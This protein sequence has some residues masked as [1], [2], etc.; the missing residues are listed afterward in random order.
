MHSLLIHLK[1]SI[2]DDQPGADPHGTPENH[3]R[4]APP[5]RGAL[6]LLVAMA[7]VLM[8]CRGIHDQLFDVFPLR[9]QM[10]DEGLLQGGDLEEGLLRISGY[11]EKFEFVCFG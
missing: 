1:D 8:S 2:P 9:R 11:N 7:D 5:F 3:L 4:G 6:Q 10:G